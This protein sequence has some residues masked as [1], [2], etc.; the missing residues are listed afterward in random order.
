MK[1]LLMLKISRFL[2]QKEEKNQHNNNV[3]SGTRK[4]NT[5]VN[6]LLI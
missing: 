3:I 1:H 4:R 6:P 5:T 2:H